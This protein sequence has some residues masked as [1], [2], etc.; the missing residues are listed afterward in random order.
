M[1]TNILI[2]AVA[3]AVIWPMPGTGQNLV[4]NGSF[5]DISS[6]PTERGEIEKAIT[7]FRGGIASP[8]LYNTCGASDTCGIPLNWAG[9]QQPASGVGY[10]G[11]HTYSSAGPGYGIHE[12]IGTELST[13]LTV[14][15]VYWLSVK[16][17]FTI[18]PALQCRMAVNNI[19]FLF[20]M[21]STIGQSA[22]LPWSNNAHFFSQAIISDTL[23]WTTIQGQFTADSAYRFVYIGNFFGDDLTDTMLVNPGGDLDMSYH[24]VD[25]VCVTTNPAYCDFEQ[26]IEDNP[27]PERLTIRCVQDRGIHVE[28]LVPG[29][30][31]DLTLFSLLGQVLLQKKV[32]AAGP[33]CWV[34]IPQVASGIYACAVSFDSERFSNLIMQTSP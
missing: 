11:M 23:E 8:D 26:G 2:Q 22:W 30:C 34:A 32:V 12:I 4:T 1:K 13:P 6:C 24:Y 25:D 17:S 18:S 19:G 15:A 7:W 14:G 3:L 31:F 16:A 21:D 29:T 5:E 27:N 28:G 33:E 10:A 9:F 20:K